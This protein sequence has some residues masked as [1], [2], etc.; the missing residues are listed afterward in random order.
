MCGDALSCDAS[1][2]STSLYC[3]CRCSF[4]SR[5]SCHDCP[6][7]CASGNASLWS[8]RT[9]RALSRGGH[10]RGAGDGSVLSRLPDLLGGGRG[11]GLLGSLNLLSGLGFLSS[12]LLLDLGGLSGLSPLG[13][14]VLSLL[15]SLIGSLA[16]TLSGC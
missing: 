15:L 6:V 11:D 1:V 16:L 5:A 13:G 12:G 2:S 10:S 8:K 14:L 7:S 3:V 4:P 9:P